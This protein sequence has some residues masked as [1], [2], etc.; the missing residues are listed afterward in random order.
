MSGG[1][2]FTHINL[3]NGLTE[4]QARFFFIEILLALKSLHTRGLIHGDVKPENVLIDE[5]GHACL[6]DYGI[7]RGILNDAREEFAS[8]KDDFANYDSAS[9]NAFAKKKES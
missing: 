4:K 5:N 9:N 7:A 6:T 2:L 1:D 8:P 3:H